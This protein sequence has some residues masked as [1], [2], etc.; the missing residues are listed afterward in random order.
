MNILIAGIFLLLMAF[1]LHLLIWKVR[2]PDNPI[3]TITIL[4]T[5]ILLGGI[6]VLRY[7]SLSN[8]IFESAALLSFS[9]CL[10]VTLIFMSLLSVYY[11]VYGALTDESPSM[12]TML[13]VA[14]MDEEGLSE[15]EL[16]ELITD[17]LFIRPRMDYLVD[18]KMVCLQEEKYRLGSKG[19]NFIGMINFFQNLMKLSV[20]AG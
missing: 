14:G 13:N 2:I 16:N 5:S 10:H 17:D 8:L 1:I 20:K 6:F 19:K 11:F 3:K 15:N 4:F 18:E 9:E 7:A 12:F